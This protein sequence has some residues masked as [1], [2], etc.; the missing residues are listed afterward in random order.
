MEKKFGKSKKEKKI[1]KNFHEFFLQIFSSSEIFD[2][3]FFYINF[4]SEI[5]YRFFLL[6]RAGGR[7]QRAAGGVGERSERRRGGVA[8]RSEAPAGRPRK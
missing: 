3:R 5:F 2:L 7:A 8:E 4:F 6:F 1:S